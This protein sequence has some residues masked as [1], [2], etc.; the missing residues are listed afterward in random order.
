MDN[1]QKVY[2]TKRPGVRL[3]KEV[4]EKLVEFCTEND[5]V[6][7]TTI[8]RFVEFCLEN[9]EIKEVQTTAEKLFIGDRE[10]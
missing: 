4:H 3:P 2:N 6:I 8:G 7:S 5:L 1:P 9:V 10:V